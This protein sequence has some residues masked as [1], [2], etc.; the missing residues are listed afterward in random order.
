MNQ[1]QV[2]QIKYWKFSAKKNWKTAELLYN[3]K[4]YDGSLFY[5]HLVLEKLLKGIIVIQTKNSAPNIHSLEKL[6]K[7]ANIEL[8]E[9]ITQNLRTITGFNIA[10]RY[11]D[12]KFEFY[13]I[14]TKKYTEQYFN[15]TKGLQIWLKKKYPKNS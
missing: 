5:C 15:I 2:N 6:A 13:K 14:C 1:N 11:D 3:N 4:H 9:S 12:E 10:A 7:L 8:T